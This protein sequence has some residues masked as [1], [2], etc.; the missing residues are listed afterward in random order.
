[1]KYEVGRGIEP[2]M[3]LD[4]GQSQGFS[5]EGPE[6]RVHDPCQGVQVNAR[7]SPGQRLQKGERAEDSRRGP[8]VNAPLFAREICVGQDRFLPGSIRAEVMEITREGSRQQVAK[9]R[10]RIAG[11]VQPQVDFAQ[12]DDKII[13][14][15]NEQLT[16]G[17]E[18]EIETADRES[19]PG[20]DIVDGGSRIPPFAE[21]LQG[22]SFEAGPALETAPLARGRTKVFARE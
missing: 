22:R 3:Q 17:S 20:R 21:E 18:L 11:Y 8:G 6:E 12:G 7:A 15:D 5:Q 4:R 2:A 16:L 13:H 10:P 9:C 1:M 14:E 19:C